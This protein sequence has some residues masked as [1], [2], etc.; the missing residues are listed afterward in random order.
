MAE[1]EDR[2][3]DGHDSDE[4]ERRQKDTPDEEETRE[5]QESDATKEDE[6]DDEDKRP[7]VVKIVLLAV[8]T[9]IFLLIGFLLFSAA[10]APTYILALILAVVWFA[11]AYYLLNRLARK[12]PHLAW[13]FRGAFIATV[14]VLVVILIVS[15]LTGKTAS[16]KLV[17][18]TKISQQR[19]TAP[20]P[21]KPQQPAPTTNTLVSTGMFH[22][23]G[24]GGASGQASLIKLANGGIVLTI[25]GL[26]VTPGPTL[27]VF[28]TPGN[29]K[30]VSHRLDL[31]SLKGNKGDQQYAV[32]PG[33]DTR[34]FASV[35]IWCK[36][37][38]VP[39]GRAVLKLQ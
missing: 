35:V 21:K 11:L 9:V 2:E 38:G 6:G 25:K 23:T 7:G 31:G 39:F 36:F 4:E 33:T 15:T 30:D 22:S 8:A 13:I 24:A 29:G 12:R 10:I 20:V 16:D 1:G 27:H 17:T 34:A 19:R 37:L 14:G 32:K 3:G 5:P 26:D 28:L 18:G